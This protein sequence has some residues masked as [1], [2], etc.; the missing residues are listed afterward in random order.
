M[1]RRLPALLRLSLLAL[2]ITACA[3]M[4][5][6]MSMGAHDDMPPPADDV[7]FIILQARCTACHSLGLVF[8]SVGTRDEWDAVIMRMAYHHKA[9][10]LTHLTDGEAMKVAAWLAANQRLDHEGVRIGYRP[11]GRPL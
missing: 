6:S 11:T 1:R 2:G 10:L 5:M 9:K 7:A 4:N 3:S 8:G